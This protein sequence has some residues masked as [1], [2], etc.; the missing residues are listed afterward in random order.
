MVKEETDELSKEEIIGIIDQLVEMGT[1]S[2]ALTGGEIF[3]REDLFE[4]VKY[5]KNRGFF[6]SLMTNGSLIRE[7]HFEEIINLKPIKFEITLYGATAEMHDNITRIKGSFEQ[8]VSAIKRLHRDGI[9]VIIKTTLMNLNFKELEDIEK[10][11]CELGVELRMN[12][13]IAPARDGST[14]TLQFDLSDEELIS[15][16]S[17]HE[18]DLGFLQEKDFTHR[19]KCKA[20]NASCCITSTGIVYPCVVM[21]VP[22]GNLRERTLKEIWNI[23]P[24]NEL[25]RLRR[26]TSQDLNSCSTCNI[27]PFCIRCPGVVYLETGDIV[28]AS[29][30]AC[31]YGA[32]R[33]YSK[34]EPHITVMQSGSKEILSPTVI[35]I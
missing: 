2:L 21:P 15:Y 1:F 26:L 33:K 30:S 11:S 29:Q 22:V 34:N 6:I 8:T 24:V 32:L 27:E 25:K 14:E 18:L 35:Q 28:G 9:K 4:I 19:F 17:T 10:L 20:G 5:A 3:I 12:P 7:E 23:H 13:G 31:R 16:M